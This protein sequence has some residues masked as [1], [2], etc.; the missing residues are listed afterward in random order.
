MAKGSGVESHVYDHE[1]ALTRKSIAA[2]KT[3]QLFIPM[4]NVQAYVHLCVKA[5]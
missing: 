5:V 2:W 4:W 3:A 1:L